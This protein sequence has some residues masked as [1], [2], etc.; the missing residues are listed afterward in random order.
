[1]QPVRDPR[2]M[3]TFM[4]EYADRHNRIRRE[5]LSRVEQAAQSI[6]DTG[7]SPKLI[8]ED[9]RQALGLCKAVRHCIEQGDDAVTAFEAFQLGLVVERIGIR[10]WEPH[11]ARGAK[12]LAGA[13]AGHEAVH[14]SP[15]QK[16]RRYR[17]YVEMWE[18]IQQEEPHLSVS[19]IDCAVAGHFGVNPKTI[20]RARLQ[21]KN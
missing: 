16:K 4:R 11:A 1:M 8:A 5:W 17:Q 6:I 21:E 19:G 10:P 9:A 14:G 18:K 12:V 7:D 13:R 20:Q 15:K 3:E 2:D